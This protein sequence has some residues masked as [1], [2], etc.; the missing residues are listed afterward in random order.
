LTVQ[1]HFKILQCGKSVFLIIRCL[2][3]G[4]IYCYTSNSIIIHNFA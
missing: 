1:V 3:W 4:N 2:L